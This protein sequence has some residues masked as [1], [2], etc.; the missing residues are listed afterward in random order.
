MPPPDS[1]ADRPRRLLADLGISPSRR[2]G[3]NFLHDRNIARKIVAGAPGEGARRLA[4]SVGRRGGE[5][6][7]GGGRP[8]AGGLPAGPVRRLGRRGGRGG[9]PFRAGRGGGEARSRGGGRR[10]GYA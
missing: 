10:G 6:G 8:E 7:G 2:R 4:V 5:D 3:Q 1:S 9:C